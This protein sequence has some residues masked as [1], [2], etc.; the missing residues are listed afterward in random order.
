MLELKII[1][2]MVHGTSRVFRMA[3]NRDIDLTALLI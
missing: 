3:G 2:Q 1:V